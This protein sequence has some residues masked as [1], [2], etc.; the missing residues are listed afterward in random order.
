MKECHGWSKP[1][2]GSDTPM[3]AFVALTDR[4]WVDGLARHE[5]VDEVNFVAV[6]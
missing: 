3:N 4:D 6:A 5:E 2:S 1:P